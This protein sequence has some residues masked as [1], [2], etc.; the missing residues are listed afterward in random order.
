VGIVRKRSCA[1]VLV[2]PRRKPNLVEAFHR[3]CPELKRGSCE[4][5]RR[6]MEGKG[7]GERG[8]G[9]RML[10][11]GGRGHHGDPPVCFGAPVRSSV[12]TRDFKTDKTGL[13]RF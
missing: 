6:G 4:L 2:V 3:G 7:E 12:A 13:V 1:S 5:T 10:R 8:E 11:R 9:V